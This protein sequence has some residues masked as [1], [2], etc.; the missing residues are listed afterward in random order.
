M[1]KA[2]HARRGDD[3]PRIDPK[4]SRPD[5]WKEAAA[6]LQMQKDSGTVR[7]YY[8]QGYIDDFVAGNLSATMAWSGDVLYY[9][10]WE[11]TR[12]SS[13][14][15]SRG[16]HAGRRGAA[17]D[18]QHADP[19]RLREPAGRLKL[20]DYVY[21][22]EIAQ[23]ITEWVAYMSPVPA[24]QGLIADHAKTEPDKATAD[25]LAAMAAS[26]LLWP[27][28]GDGEQNLVRTRAHHRRRA[29]GVGLD[30]PAHLREL[31]GRIHHVSTSSSPQPSGPPPQRGGRAS[32][33]A[34][35]RCRTRCSHPGGVYLFLG[36]LLPL[37]LIVITSL[38]SGGLLSGGL[39]LHVG[40][41]ELHRR[42]LA[43][44]GASSAS[45]SCISAIAT[46]IAIL[47][48]Y[49]MAYWIAFYGG[50]W[51]STLFF[52]ILVPFFVTFV[53]RTVQWKFILGDEGL[54]LGPL[55]NM[56]LRAGELQRPGQPRRG[57]LRHHV[58]LPAVH[59]AAPV[60]VARADRP[61][62][63]R[64][65]QGPVRHAVRG[66]P[67]GGAAPVVPGPVRR[68][69]PHVRAGDRRLREL[70]VLGSSRTS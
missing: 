13:S 7:T 67:Q 30:L 5:D 1:L 19:G 58:Q 8:D 14:C 2:G 24:V 42:A 66:V 49:P 46:T 38:K 26:P 60:R 29:R 23:L 11:A 27:D 56:G 53:I 16:V 3:R 44:Q 64:G 32:G 15:R 59:G 55:K 52:M 41:L 4:T 68:R 10:I 39:P 35:G 20:M 33:G 70:A 63:R 61:P 18:R 21:Q 50:R 45:R 6:W 17:V 31:A 9:K 40:V 57:H 43:V 36:F 65:R 12:S 54:L 37:V 69:H 22:P 34:A 51:K 25:A 62:P 28:D 47:L 48:A